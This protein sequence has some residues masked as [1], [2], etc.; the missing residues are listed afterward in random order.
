MGLEWERRRQV[1]GGLLGELEGTTYCQVEDARRGRR[2]NVLF[3]LRD[4]GI[5]VELQARWSRQ[6]R[7][8]QE[9]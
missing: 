3:L 1:G 6:F 9:K 7:D 5:G 2:L 8:L 4:L